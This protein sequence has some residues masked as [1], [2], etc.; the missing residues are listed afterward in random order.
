[1]DGVTDRFT[2]ETASTKCSKA[3]EAFMVKGMGKTS[4]LTP[5]TDN[6]YKQQPTTAPALWEFLAGSRS[7]PE[8]MLGSIDELELDVLSENSEEPARAHIL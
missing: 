7:S 3:A 2:L 8:D 4:G 5:F 6:E 1:V